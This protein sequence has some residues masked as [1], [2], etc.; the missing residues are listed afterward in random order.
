MRPT[1][2]AI[3]RILKNSLEEHVIP[4]LESHYARGQAGQIA[5]TLE[6]LADGW[7]E[8]LQ[9]TR[10]GNAAVRSSLMAV[11]DEL[12]KLVQ[13]DAAQKD[14]W[15]AAQS[16]LGDMLGDAV[17]DTAAA[18]DADRDRVFKILDDL[19]IAAGAPMPGT[20]GTGPLWAALLASL[21]QLSEAETYYGQIPLPE[22]HW[23]AT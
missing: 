15:A 6:W 23:V 20:E 19:V 10:E 8:P 22:E 11:N 2:P 4:E 21:E 18:Q 12:V 1:V 9:K 3:L 5:L 17:E 13:S 16:Q 7:V 14:H